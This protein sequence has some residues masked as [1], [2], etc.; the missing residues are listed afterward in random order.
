MPVE[1]RYYY[2]QGYLEWYASHCS[3]PEKSQKA[4]E[5]RQDVLDTAA[6]LALENEIKN[7]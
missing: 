3:S 4:L 5:V 6:A 7:G 2:L 1:R